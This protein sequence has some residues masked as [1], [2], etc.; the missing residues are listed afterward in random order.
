MNDRIFNRK[1]SSCEDL[2]SVVLL[3]ITKWAHARKE[4]SDLKIDN[5]TQ[6][7]LACLKMSVVKKKKII[8][9]CSPPCGVL[10]FN[11]DRAAKGNHKWEVMYMF[12]KHV[13]IK[14]SIEVKV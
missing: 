11:V 13:G 3:R 6:I 2:L 4:F 9:Y 5:F 7:F 12:S 1:E 14:D 10:K 8:P